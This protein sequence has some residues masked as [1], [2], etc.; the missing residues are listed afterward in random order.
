V[1]KARTVRRDPDALFATRAAARKIPFDFV[2]VEL[3]ELGPF[4]RPMF[5]CTAVYVDDKIVFIL[6]DKGKPRADDGVWVA[7]VHEHH[8][9]LRR[10]LPMLRSISV[11]AEGGVTGW[12]M[13]PV[14]AEGFEEGALRA[15]A[16]VRAG[17]PRIGKVPASRRKAAN[18][19]AGAARTQASPRPVKAKSRRAR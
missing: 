16:L 1:A 3:A 19:G 13:I 8:A 7:T 5:G 11:L 15:C 12:Q 17:D 18:R 10:E 2:L 9:S 14:D 6:R 4:T